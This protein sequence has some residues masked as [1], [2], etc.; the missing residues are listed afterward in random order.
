MTR[1]HDLPTPALLLDLDVAERNVETMA[2]RARRL[3]VALRPHFKTSK[4][5]DVARLQRHRGAAGHTVATLEE[6]RVLFEHGFDDLTWAFPAIPS[7]LAQARDLD[8]PDEGRRLRLTVDTPE[9]VAAIEATGHPFHVWLEVDSGDHRCGIDPKGD[10]AV[11]L[12]RCITQSRKLTFDGLLT[13]GGQAYEARG[14]AEL[15]R[16]AET[17]RRVVVGL[18]ERLR[19]QG[20]EVPGVSV[21]STPGMSAAEHLEGVTEARPGNYVFYDAMQVEIGSCRVAD[22]ALTV[23]ATVVSQ[24]PGAEHSVVDAGALALSKDT[25]LEPGAWGRLVELEQPAKP[26]WDAKLTALSQ[27]HGVVDAPLPVGSKVRILPN[28]SCL[29]VACWDEYHVTRGVEVIDR[30]KI[31]RQ[32]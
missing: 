14:R 17:E 9:A 1:I 18:A 29:T 4:C 26:R 28:H 3:G 7:R 27:E 13:H 30:W 21:G 15:E 10:R 8:R 5:V 32:R 12:A 11:A 19:Q 24:Q 22:C 20:L 2:E 25:G 16:V 31:W 6:A 23:L